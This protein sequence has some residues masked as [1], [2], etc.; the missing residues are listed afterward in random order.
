M[1]LSASEIIR[2]SFLLYKENWKLF[3]TYALLL[4]VPGGLISILGFSLPYIMAYI[5]PLLAIIVY[6]FLLIGLTVASLWLSIAMIKTI[7]DRYQKTPAKKIKE[8]LTLSKN[9]IWPVLLT[10]LLSGLAV[11][12]SFIMFIIPGIIFSVW[13][14]FSIYSAVLESKTPVEAMKHS[15]NLSSGRWGSVLWRLIAPAIIFMIAI[16]IVQWI[17]DLPLELIV[18]RINSVKAIII[19]NGFRK[20]LSTLINIIAGPLT[21]TAIAILYIDLKN[22]KVKTDE[23][24]ITAKA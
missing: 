4:L 6:V 10:S 13:F 1:L 9:L 20:L 24:P 12:A 8:E 18:D 22:K 2:K 17:I 21:T 19:L 11:T 15:K 16:G 7:V 5:H 14:A 23:P 3:L